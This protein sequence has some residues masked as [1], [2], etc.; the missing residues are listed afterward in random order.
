MSFLSSKPT[1][2]FILDKEFRKKM[3]QI[4]EDFLCRLEKEKEPLFFYYLN[5]LTKLAEP[6]QI[7]CSKC[8]N[9]F[10][11][12]VGFAQHVCEK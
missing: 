11:S 5:Q 9:K 8:N 12:N 3:D 4:Q 6:S 7:R 10:Y 1:P 2:F